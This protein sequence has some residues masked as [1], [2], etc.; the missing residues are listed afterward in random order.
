MSSRIEQVLEVLQEVKEE[1]LKNQSQH[2][3]SSLRKKAVQRVANKRQI[4]QNSVADKYI[5]QLKPYIQKTDDF[6]KFLSSWLVKGDDKI[7]QIL[8]TRTVT[9]SDKDYINNFFDNLPVLIPKLIVPSEQ[10]EIENGKEAIVYPEESPSVGTYSEGNSK[11]VSV[12]VYE[13]NPK[14]KRD[15]I[16]VYGTAC[17]VCGFRFDEH[18]GE[19]G[20]EFIHIHHLE[21]I[22]TLG[23]NYIVNPITDLRPVCPNCHA[24]I[25][26]RNPPFTI[27]ELKRVLSKTHN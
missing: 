3:I 26:K 4:T 19:I 25:H 5:R 12:N 7:Q 8:L 11:R 17:S 9:Q 24:M 16:A 6:D 21:M 10:I 18:Y 20:K 15:C 1:Y 2:P 22:S 14:A 27:E 23:V 13:R